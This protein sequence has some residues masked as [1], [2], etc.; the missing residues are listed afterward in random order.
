[1]V[2]VRDGFNGVALLSVESVASVPVLLSMNAKKESLGSIESDSLAPPLPL[3]WTVATSS[4]RVG[5]E[6]RLLKLCDWC[7]GSLYH[8][9]A[10]PP[11][12][13][14][15]SDDAEV[16]LAQWE[17]E[18][19]GSGEQTSGGL[20]NRRR[21]DPLAVLDGARAVAVDAARRSAVPPVVVGAIM[22]GHSSEPSDVLAELLPV[23]VHVLVLVASVPAR[24]ALGSSFEIRLLAYGTVPIARIRQAQHRSSSRALGI[25]MSSDLQSLVVLSVVNNDDNIGKSSLELRLLSRNVAVQPPQPPHRVGQQQL[26]WM[27]DAFRCAVAAQL[28]VLDAGVRHALRSAAFAATQWAAGVDAPMASLLTKL[29]TAI[30]KFHEDGDASLAQLERVAASYFPQSRTPLALLELHRTHTI[31]ATSGAVQYWAE[32][33]VGDAGFVAA[34][35]SVENAIS[36]VESICV[37]HIARALE[38]V[39]GAVAT[40]HAMC[41]TENLVHSQRVDGVPLEFS[42]AH[43]QCLESEVSHALAMV[44][45]VRCTVLHARRSHVAVLTY[46][47]LTARRV[48]AAVSASEDSAEGRGGGGAALLPPMLHADDEDLVRAAFAPRADPIE[49]GDVDNA[50]ARDVTHYSAEARPSDDPLGLRSA[51]AADPLGM[52]FGRSPL[53]DDLASAPLS[54][55]GWRTTWSNYQKADALLSLAVGDIIA[56]AN[57]SSGNYAGTDAW[58]PASPVPC[59]D[60]VTACRAAARVPLSCS[61]DRVSAGQGHDAA[62]SILA[63]NNE[64]RRMRSIGSQVL[65][66]AE[67]AYNLTA[68]LE[69]AGS[70][71]WSAEKVLDASLVVEA[72]P[73]VHESAGGSNNAS[74]VTARVLARVCSSYFDD[75]WRIDVGRTK[76]D[77]DESTIGAHIIAVPV[78]HELLWE[79]NA[80]APVGDGDLLLNPPWQ[81]LPNMLGGPPLLLMLRVVAPLRN[82]A[83]GGENLPRVSACILQLPRGQYGR[84]LATA[85]YGHSPGAATA[86]AAASVVAHL[87]G[88]TAPAMAASSV[89]PRML[90]VLYA[91]GSSSGAGENAGDDDIAADPRLYLAQINY[92]DLSFVELPQSAGVAAS[93][94]LTTATLNAVLSAVSA[95]QGVVQIDYMRERQLPSPEAVCALVR[96]LATPNVMTS[97][98]AA[99]R[100]AYEA[101]CASVRVTVSGPRGIGAV[102]LGDR[103]TVLLDM[104]E[105]EVLDD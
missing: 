39:M 82:A 9:L 52:S 15:S 33:M 26:S 35:R 5:G 70:D 23:S 85:A 2:A 41:M 90:S 63:E 91:T 13:P 57:G 58:D 48:A 88:A 42:A 7:G 89:N 93:T 100:S 45:L 51:D 17:E 37:V 101:A 80:L 36:A 25:S 18:N 97:D 75:G 76:A 38:A 47:R 64:P 3:A 30:H 94:L 56:P 95:L 59:P 92:R 46:G 44:E 28:C 49:F 66:L 16:S 27:D 73:L 24:Y 96:I 104:E 21:G 4:N 6:L 20:V 86:V 98:N 10:P 77:D 81:R 1:M 103:R 65:W 74:D 53:N 50:P 60:V 32:T 69:F 68:A 11:L 55:P 12:P 79:N 67:R 84:V 62:D 72:E 102:T 8:S 54:A 22:R 14:L 71:Q 99:I 87:A 29:D 34:Q 83:S 40:L 61:V 78:S 105:D 43:L 19:A 31:G